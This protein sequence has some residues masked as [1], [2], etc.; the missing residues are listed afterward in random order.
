MRHAITVLAMMC[1]TVVATAGEVTYVAN[2]GPE[3]GSV[4][5]AI[6]AWQFE[7]PAASAAG[8]VWSE[9]VVGKFMSPV[10]GRD[11]G[12]LAAL[13][14]DAADAKKP[15]TLR[16]NFDGKQEFTKEFSLEIQ[17]AQ[18]Q[19]NMFYGMFGQKV[20]KVKRGQ[21]TIPL[22][23]QGTVTKGEYQAQVGNAVAGA[24]PQFKRVAYTRITMTAV[25]A[26]E[27]T[28]KFGDKSY[29]VRLADSN[30]NFTYTDP[31]KI[32]RCYGT[33]A[34]YLMQGDGLMV[35]TGD[36]KFG[37]DCEIGL[38]GQP[39]RVAGKWYE[40]T[41]AEDLTKITAKAMDVPMA[42][43]KVASDAWTCRLVSKETVLSLRGGKDAMDVPAGE[44]M[45]QEY[46]V[47]GSTD[48]ARRGIVPSITGNCTMADGGKSEAIKLD[49]GKTIDLAIG[50]PLKASVKAVSNV[51]VLGG[52]NV[53]T[54]QNMVMFSL[55]FSDSGGHKVTSLTGN[56]GRP[57]APKFE[58]IDSGGK[59][60]YES[61]LEYG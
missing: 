61:T 9:A 55:V 18:T 34:P 20:L 25:S 53:K 44:Y 33:A 59:T 19:G 50:A 30:C 14:A 15:T 31:T 58:V 2:P 3:M 10:N 21:Q 12:I 8:T 49:S 41:V 4:T 47:T 32:V 13:D 17:A 35:D 7:K 43:I 28:V 27:A 29:P 22:W 23:V 5:T 1:L 48:S 54:G 52:D 16:L 51:T 45:I 42:T 56:N 39:V 11:T 40:L 6:Q 37:K 36:G 60:I 57:P 24:K 26:I 38:S 46:T